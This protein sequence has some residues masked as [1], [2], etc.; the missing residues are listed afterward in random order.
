[1]IMYTCRQDSFA[2][3]LAKSKTDHYVGR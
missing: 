3:I 2:N 1:M